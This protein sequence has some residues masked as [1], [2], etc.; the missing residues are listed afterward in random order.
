[1]CKIQ[2]DPASNG[3]IILVIVLFLQ[4]LLYTKSYP[5]GLLGKFTIPL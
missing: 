2:D 3:F 5:P 1:M 4:Q